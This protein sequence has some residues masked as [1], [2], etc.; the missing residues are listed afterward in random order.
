MQFVNQLYVEQN[1]IYIY[2][3]INDFKSIYIIV[4]L[5]KNNLLKM[6]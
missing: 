4:T 3:Y 1:F 6:R 5:L 2:I